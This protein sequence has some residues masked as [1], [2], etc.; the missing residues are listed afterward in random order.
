MKLLKNGN[1]KY[2]NCTVQSTPTEK[3]PKMVTVIKTPH[4]F[5]VLRNRKFVDLESTKLSIEK[6]SAEAMI[7]GGEKSV[8]KQ[9]TSLQMGGEM[10]Y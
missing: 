5:K 9:L 3:F 1:W 6:Y 4:R 10:N 7:K 8:S 2:R